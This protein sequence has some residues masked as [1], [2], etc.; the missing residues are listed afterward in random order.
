MADKTEVCT[1]DNPRT[2]CRECWQNGQL[3]RSYDHRLFFL[4][5][6]IPGEYFF[7]GANSGA[8]EEGKLAGNSSALAGEEEP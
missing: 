4:P 3:I 1:Y 8:W 5:E 7:F 2:M 6:P